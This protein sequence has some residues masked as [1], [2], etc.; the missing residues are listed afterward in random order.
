[1]LWGVYGDKREEV[2][3]NEENFLMKVL[4]N[5]TSRQRDQMKTNMLDG[6]LYTLVCV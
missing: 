2:K 5:Y 1:M 4:I 3:G 6:I